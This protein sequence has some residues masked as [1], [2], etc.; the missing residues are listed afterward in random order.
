MKTKKSVK[1][2]NFL[3]MFGMYLLMALGIL[4]N[5]FAFVHGEKLCS[6]TKNQDTIKGKVYIDLDASGTFDAAKDYG[7]RGAPVDLLVGCTSTVI[8]DSTTTDVNGNYSFINL[9]DGMYTVQIREGGEGAPS[10]TPSPKNCCITLDSFSPGNRYCDLGYP[11]PDCTSN[12]YSVDNVCDLAYNNPLCDLR[13]IGDFACGQNPTYLGP[14]SGQKNCSGEYQ[15]TS[16]FG[17]VAGTGNYSIQ[18]TIFSC[19]GTGVQY[20]LMDVCSPGGPY[21]VC[22]GSAKTGTV[23]VDASGLEPCKTYVF[24]MDGYS[25]SVCSYYIQVVGDFHL[26]QIPLNFDIKVVNECSS[27]LCQ[28]FGTFPVSIVEDPNS[29]Y[30]L[31]NIKEL[32]LHWEVKRDGQPL[33]QNSKVTYPAKDGLTV[34]MPFSQAGEYEICVKTL[35]ACTRYNAPKCKKI[36]INTKN[37]PTITK[38]IKLKPSDFPWSG[39]FNTD[40]SPSLD[41]YGNQ[42]K[43]QSGS[44]KLKQVEAKGSGIFNSTYIY[45]LCGCKYQQAIRVILEKPTKDDITIKSDTITYPID[46]LGGNIYVDNRLSNV[47]DSPVAQEYSIFPNPTNDNLSIVSEGIEPYFVEI[48]NINGQSLSSQVE[49]VFHTLQQTDILLDNLKA[50]MYFVKISSG[51]QINFERIIKY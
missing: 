24:W 34:N 50:G 39:A 19:A 18:F 32:E 36:Q 35:H 14:W 45:P 15:N 6:Q 33:P 25:G 7:F 13:V 9:P 30:S 42:W 40:G 4:P 16:F 51:D 43:W 44:I 41:Q 8:F 5:T 27:K 23:T 26:C 31:K 47:I 48:F 38:T 20:G 10:S 46:S 1:W 2:Q 21:I 22:N 28:G 49:T 29:N 17:F 37:L 3:M 12:P 11:P